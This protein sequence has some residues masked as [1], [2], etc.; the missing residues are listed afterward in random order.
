VNIDYFYPPEVTAPLPEFP[1]SPDEQELLT[2]YRKLD[3]RARGI[4]I[5]MAHELARK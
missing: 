3:A 2:A 5:A 1:L 4:L